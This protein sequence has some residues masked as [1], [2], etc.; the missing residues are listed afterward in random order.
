MRLIITGGA[1]FI[2]SAAVRRFISEGAAVLNIDK[3]T[4]AG[5]LRA[6]AG[7]EANPGYQFLQAD[8]VDAEAMAAAFRDFQPTAVIHLAAESHVD[9]SIDGPADFLTTN[10]I[11]T[12]VML[13]AALS[14][15]RNARRGA[16]EFRFVLVSTDEVYG[17]LGDTGIFSET[18]AYAPNSPYSA[19]KASADHLARAWHQTY[20]LPTI[21]TNCSNNYGPYQNSEKL[22]PTVIRTALAGQPIPVY[23]N[24]ENIRD[25]LFVDDH[26]QG[27]MD[28][29]TRG[30]PGQKYNFG[31]SAERS[32]IRLVRSICEL[33]DQRLPRPDGASYASFIDFVTDR[34]GHDFRYA[35]DSSRAEHDLG[36]RRKETLDSGL[37][38]TVDWYLDNRDWIASKQSFGRLGLTGGAANP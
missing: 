38:R 29:L 9:R 15:C 3:L 34:P 37:A 11:G 16:D 32:N 35:I 7:C 25:W 4:Y 20:G 2:G 6:V 17:S 28:T 10:I 18:A 31:G 13:E 30:K 23:G 19:S 1:G 12:Y 21:V 33:L 24:G 27:L 8:I 26:V 22:I 36:W 14:H 5:D